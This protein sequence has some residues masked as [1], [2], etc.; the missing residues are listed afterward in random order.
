MLARNISTKVLSYLVMTIEKRIKLNQ[1]LWTLYRRKTSIK[2]I[3][4]A[5]GTQ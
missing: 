5:Q 2:E 3:E 1:G 4:P